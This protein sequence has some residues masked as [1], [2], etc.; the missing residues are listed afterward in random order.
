M[1]I[2]PDFNARINDYLSCDFTTH[3]FPEYTCDVCMI[4][5]PGMLLLFPYGRSYEA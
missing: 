3:L 2:N 4:R 1:A 5:F